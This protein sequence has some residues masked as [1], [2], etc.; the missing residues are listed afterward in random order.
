MDQRYA[1]GDAVIYRKYKHSAAPGPRAKGIEPEP[2]GEEYSYR[3]DK[4]WLVMEVCGANQVVLI[5]RR[6]KQHRVYMDDP[7]LRPARW[8]ER[9]L[10]HARF[11]K[12]QHPPGRAEVA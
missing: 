12:I 5:T 6:G 10:Y 3:V 7:N 2:H 11:P 1:R 9:I 8:W 4:F